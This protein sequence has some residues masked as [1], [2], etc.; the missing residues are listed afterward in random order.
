MKYRN[1]LFGLF[2]VLISIHSV[3]A[4]SSDKNAVKIINDMMNLVKTNAVKTNFT[5][6]I[7]ESSSNQTHKTDGSFTMKSNKFI[8]N[9]DQMDVFF[10]G[11]TQWAYMTEMN[12]VSITNPSEKELA[13]TNPMAILSTYQNKSVIKFAKKNSSKTSYPIELTPSAKNS[14]IKKILVIVNK[15]NY[16]PLS[17]QLTDKK[18]MISLLTL[19]QFKTGLKISDNAFVFDVKSHKGIEINDLR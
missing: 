6:S 12:E 2:V 15:N 7:K 17:I 10:D 16:Y 3:N 19:S 18:G 8:L 14:D 13:E 4:Q 9:M 11:K 5:M 1:V